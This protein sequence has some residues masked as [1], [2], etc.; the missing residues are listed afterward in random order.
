ML[1]PTTVKP[2]I[3]QPRQDLPFDM[4]DF[5]VPYEIGILQQFPF[6]S[7]QQCMSV[8]CRTIGARHMTVYTKGA[9]EK[10]QI[11]CRPESLPRDFVEVLSNYTMSGY[12]VIAIAFKNLPRKLMWK[13]ALKMKRDAVSF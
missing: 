5:E 1:V 13:D 10:L 4:A 12:R 3:N 11:M 9:P 2:K 7:A 6:S 8:I